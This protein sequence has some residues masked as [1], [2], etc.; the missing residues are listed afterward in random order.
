M[1]LI[2]EREM[3]VALITGGSRGLGRSAAL[4]LAKQ[5][6]NIIIT[7][8]SNKEAA[9]E[10]VAEIKFLGLKA[11]AIQLDVRDIAQF[12]NFASEVVQTIKSFNMAGLDFIVN[13]AGTGLHENFEETT[14]DQFED[15]YQIHLRAP[16]FLTQ[17]LLPLMN[18]GGHI[19]NISSGLAR[20]SLPG[21]SAYAMMKGGIEVMTRYLAREL[22]DRQISV[23]TLAP[24][25]IATDFNGGAVRDNPQINQMISATT[26]KGRV[27]EADDIGKAIAMLLTEK[28]AWITGQR[29]EASGGTLL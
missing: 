8:H 9:E 11:K 6:T 25:A 3:T 29:I 5:K 21:Y 12:E 2:K 4:E 19:L 1:D 16:Y 27:G 28:S 17:K 22:G 26:A 23:N 18:N 14:P 15:L 10:V 20:F 13:N 7:Y 24:G